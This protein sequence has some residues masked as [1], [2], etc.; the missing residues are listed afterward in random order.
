MNKK[1]LIA[2]DDQNI[3]LLISEALDEL[4]NNGVELIFASDGEEAVELAKT[5]RPG[6][7]ILDIM[8]PHK[9]GY[10]VCK[11][12]REMPDTWNVFII[13]LSARGSEVTRKTTER[14][15]A[16]TYIAKP[17][18]PEELLSIIEKAL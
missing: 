2:D 14:V 12:I 18:E 8:M 4:V 11:E 7:M 3:R 13:I 10:E 1:I 15:G 17:F 5:H 6:I 9:T 16:N